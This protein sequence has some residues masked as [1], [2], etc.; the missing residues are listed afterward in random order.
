MERALFV[1]I[2][3]GAKIEIL[4]VN[5]KRIVQDYNF[6]LLNNNNLM[7]RTYTKL[8]LTI[9]NLIKNTSYKCK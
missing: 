6:A 9:L 4:L 5:H 2:M 7:I 1:G 8:F 3:R